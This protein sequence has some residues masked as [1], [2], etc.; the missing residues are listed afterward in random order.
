[1]TKKILLIAYHF[2]PST[3]VG[4]VRLANFAAQLPLLGWQTMVLTLKDKYLLKSDPERLKPL[5][6]IEITK[7]E[8]LPTLSDTYLWLKR[9]TQHLFHRPL[10][11]ENTPSVSR[12]H[13]KVAGE[14]MAAKLRRYILS[15]LSIPD[16]QRN[17]VWPAAVRAV[18]LI[19]RKQ[20]DVILTSCP[21][22]SAH[23]VGLI[24]KRFTN[25]RWV[26]DFRDPW[27]ATP[28][29][30]LYCTCAASLGV[31]RWLER[32]V[33]ENADLVV[34]NTRKLT[35]YFTA[36]YGTS[37]LDKFVTVTNGFDGEVF[38]RFKDCRKESVFT[39]TYAGTLYFGRTPE[40]IFKAVQELIKD[41]SIP[42]ASLRIRLVGN[43]RLI[44]GVP[45]GEL[46]KTYGLG[47]IVEVLGPVSQTE[48]LRL[49]RQSHIALL[50]APNQPFQIPAKL[51]EY[52][53]M[54]TVVLALAHEGATQDLVERT[55]VG[56]VFRPPDIA[57]M[58]DFI[59][60]SY[61]IFMERGELPFAG[62]VESFEV[63]RIT[64]ILAEH[65]NRICG[66]PSCP[67]ASA[68]DHSEK[69]KPI[70]SMLGG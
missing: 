25:V 65:L 30:S 31:E 32:Q 28:A 14:S 1:M 16:A 52:M 9:A 5:G 62:V 24:V 4:G 3:E 29:K 60:K 17:W 68:V 46:V 70:S 23:L 69:N 45:T 42:S 19:K 61:G 63:S 11:N 55:G 41:G 56:A 20:I 53:G 40:P 51:Y 58:K 21:P 13:K 33:I 59:L 15:F 8:R 2:P 10:T 34:S 67:H 47:N 44:N 39:I 22:Y 38:S 49:I 57:G 12:S 7:A 36:T 27:M 26:A 66:A 50:L 64:H 6:N 37:K 43:C 54:Q 18:W 48:A 35:E